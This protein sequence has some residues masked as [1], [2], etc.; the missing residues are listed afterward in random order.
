M[1]NQETPDI[2]EQEVLLEGGRIAFHNAFEPKP[3]MENGQAKGAPTYN[4]TML[5]RPE[6]LADAKAVAIK[7]AKGKWGSTEGVKFPFLRGQNE[8]AKA[9]KRAR[10]KNKANA[11]K[12]GDFYGDNI[13][14]KAH[15]KYAVPVYDKTGKEMVAQK[16]LY[17]GAVATVLVK[18][19]ANEVSGNKYI[20]SYLQGVKKT[21]DGDR[22][23]GR[24]LGSVFG[25]IRDT[26]EDLGTSSADL[27]E[28]IQF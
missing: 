5:Y 2:G 15:T 23:F 1:P 13:V 10:A 27:D 14:L 18:F 3:Y 25:G 28:T 9:V 6:Q 11:D 21:G 24:D 4:I 7:V 19:V 22:L 17:S 8:A 26:D 16:D 12:A 20:T